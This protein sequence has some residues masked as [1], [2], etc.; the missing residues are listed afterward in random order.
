MACQ[1]TRAQADG[2]T[3][4]QR[5]RESAPQREAER[6]DA[7]EDWQCRKPK[8]KEKPSKTGK[9]GVGYKCSLLSRLI[10]SRLGNQWGTEGLDLSRRFVLERLTCLAVSSAMLR[11][12]A[13]AILLVAAALTAWACLEDLRPLNSPAAPASVMDASAPVRRPPWTRASGDDMG[14]AAAVETWERR[15]RRGR[16]RRHRSA[17]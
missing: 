1:R 10:Y 11:P 13:S 7:L 4:P 14:T 2:L 17:R 5:G 15:R 16:W 3:H 6:T 12:V 9:I 8:V